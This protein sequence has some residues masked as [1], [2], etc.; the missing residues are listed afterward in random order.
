MWGALRQGFFYELDA[1]LMLTVLASAILIMIL[2]EKKL[3]VNLFQ[4]LLILF[5]IVYWAALF[6]AQDFELAMEEALK[7]TSMP[8]I[9]FVAARLTYNNKLK[10]L[11]LCIWVGSSLVVVGVLFNLYRQNRLEST[12]EY[13]NTLAIFLL[14]TAILCILFYLHE[15]KVGLLFHLTLQISGLLLTLSRSVWI[16]WIAA[17]LLLLLS[18]KLLRTRKQLARFSFVQLAA[19][20]LAVLIK[21]DLFFFLNRV[22]SIQAKASELQIRFV[23]WR[24]SLAMIRDHFLLGT[25]GGGWSVLLPE[26]SDPVYFVKY[27][28][29][30]YLQIFMDVG[31]VG[32]VIFISILFVFYRG[33]GLGIMQN[34]ESRLWNKGFVIIV[35]FILLHAGFDFDL[36]FPLMLGVVVLVLSIGSEN[37]FNLTIKNQAYYRLSLV[38]IFAFL[39]FS[40][41][42]TTG[43]SFMK[44]GEHNIQSNIQIAAAQKQF[45]TAKWFLPWSSKA[46]YD[47]AKGYVLLGN[48]TN[49]SASYQKAKEEIEKAIQLSPKQSLYQALLLELQQATQ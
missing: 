17:I 29:N 44:K 15:Q 35:T 32:L 10:L 34:E 6:Y 43:Y 38:S 28:H 3:E 12:I 18:Y 48:Q 9:G 49:D 19:L 5:T 47:A 24:D 39:L 25:G 4:A 1:V 8:L 11:K 2:L 46:Y 31:L 45:T 40:A 22:H 36:S 41:W 16:L 26:Y 20:G 30:Q 37:L 42:L 27:V 33:I 21:W 13:A 14:V 7:V 23:Y